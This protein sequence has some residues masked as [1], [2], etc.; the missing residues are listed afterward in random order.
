MGTLANT[1][2]E[3]T[4]QPSRAMMSDLRGSFVVLRTLVEL[5]F[6][7][8]PIVRSKMIVLGSSRKQGIP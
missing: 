1:R 2:T 5:E 3:P 4:R 8:R 7:F 6:F